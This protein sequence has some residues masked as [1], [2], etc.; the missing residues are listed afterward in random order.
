M[1]GRIGS[2]AKE[3]AALVGQGGVTLIELMV[4]IAI[5][6][7]VLGIAVPSFTGAMLDSNLKSYADNLSSSALLARSEAIKRNT[8]VTLCVSSSGTSCGT[9]SWEQGWIV[10]S[11]ASVLHQQA[12]LPA[13]I[14]VVES[15]GAL[16]SIDFRPTGVAATPANFTVCRAT[17]SVG[18]HERVVAISPTGRT[19]VTKTTNG[20]CP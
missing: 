8:A 1:N 15:G 4:T 9:G 6:A 10:I 3:P 11:G 12:A 16:E 7:I 13:G 5:F 18:P 20:A 19:S 2:R 14:L 17:P